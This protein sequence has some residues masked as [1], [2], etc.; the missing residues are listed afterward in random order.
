M[1]RMNLVV[2]RCRDIE[3][4]RALYASLGLAFELHQHGTGAQ[5]YA[6]ERDGWVFELYPLTAT[7]TSGARIGFAVDDI[8]AAVEAWRQAGGRVVR[9]PA[10]S[11]WGRRAVLQDSDGHK[12][13]LTGG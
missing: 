10:T 9:E 3:S 8:D 1:I 13:E 2:L 12:V 11:P 7:S 4:S 6:C 5:H